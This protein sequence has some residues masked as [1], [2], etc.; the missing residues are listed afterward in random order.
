MRVMPPQKV[1]EGVIIGGTEQIRV[2]I[3]EIQGDS[4]L[5]EISGPGFESPRVIETQGHTV[6][7][8][9]PETAGELLES[10]R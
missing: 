9:L 1:N 10:V 4:V 6:R 3:L 7:I 8:E 2:K 5:L